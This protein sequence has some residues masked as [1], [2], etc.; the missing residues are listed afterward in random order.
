MDTA[1]SE[2]QV[3]DLYLYHRPGVFVSTLPIYS[4]L[5]FAEVVAIARKY[6]ALPNSHFAHWTICRSMGESNLKLDQ[7]AAVMLADLK[8]RE[9]MF[10]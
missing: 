7:M 8:D 9:R 4:S 1:F 3:F 5:D 10:A 6:E 2:L